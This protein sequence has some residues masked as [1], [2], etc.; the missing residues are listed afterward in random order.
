MFLVHQ[1]AYLVGALEYHCERVAKI[2]TGISKQFASLP[3]GT[4]EADKG[5]FGYQADPY[6]E[7][8][9]AVTV[10][11]RCS[12]V[13]RYLLW[14]YFGPGRGT[15]PRSFAKTVPLCTPLPSELRD[16]LDQSWE[17]FG[18]RITDYCDCLQHYVPVDFGVAT[19]WME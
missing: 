19:A 5:T 14:E 17:R 9:A 15:M 6:Y 4:D 10:A 1:A 12:D 13:S 16:R 11:R 7:F 18:T 3:I 2:Y 8:D